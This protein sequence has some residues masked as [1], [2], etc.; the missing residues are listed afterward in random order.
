VLITAPST[1]TCTHDDEPTRSSTLDSWMRNWVAL[2]PRESTPGAR[3]NENIGV[4]SPIVGSA[5]AAIAGWASTVVS[6]TAHCQATS[7]TI[8]TV[9]AI[10]ATTTTGLLPRRVTSD[11]VPSAPGPP[12]SSSERDPGAPTVRP[13]SASGRPCRRR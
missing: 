11:S 8:V 6:A 1:A 12:G 4:V 7:S 13:G 3:R 9:T 10:E 5:V 2:S